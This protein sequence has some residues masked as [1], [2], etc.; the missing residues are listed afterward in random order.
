MWISRWRVP[1]AARLRGATID[2]SHTPEAD[3]SF[4]GGTH[5]YQREFLRLQTGD[6]GPLRS[7]VSF[8]H[9]QVD[10]WRGDGNANVQKIDAKTILTLSDDATISGSV[11][12][13]HELK[14]AYD[15]LSKAQANANYYA[16]WD[17]TLLTP[18]DTNY[19]RLH[20][21]PF[22]KLPCEPRRRIPRHPRPR[23]SPWCRTFNT[24]AAGA[25]PVPHLPKA[26]RPV[27]TADMPTPMRTS[28]T[29]AR[30]AARPWCMNWPEPI[31]G[32]PASSPRSI[33][34]VGRDDTL[35]A[36]LWVDVPRQEQNEPFT[37]TV[38]GDPTDVWM[39]N[40]AN[41]LTY[42]G[43]GGPQFL[44]NEYTKTT[45]YRGF[46]QDTWTPTN[47]W[48]LTAGVAYTTIKRDGFDFEY[49]GAT[50]GPSYQQSFGG[51]TAESYSKFTP[52]A[53]IK[54]SLTPQ[55]QFYAGFGRTF[56]A[57]INGAV[58]QNAAVLFY[59]EANPSEKGF[60]GITP[61]QLAAIAN[62]QPETSDTVD[63][64]WR[65]YGRSHF[66]QRRC[67]RVKPEE[68]AGLWV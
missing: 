48:T 66:S 64:G 37:G 59:Y 62:N 49:S 53:G 32:V 12:Y 54:F 22:D 2:P 52:T 1:R 33:Q 68:Q 44:Y 19:W 51:Y 35:E 63:V 46:L 4:S 6:T 30:S 8:S 27:T 42:I 3:L 56:R 11:Q 28:I 24:A 60:S 65:Y 13:N 45:L 10:L 17:T 16:N 43:T 55:N 5:A 25:A 57:P 50:G 26:L 18:T 39:K 29:T 36:G 34:Q 31:P 15:T 61:A 21:N 23:V 7:W 41:I 40:G 20:T 9:N 47:Q 38:A 14:Y 58:L 67:L